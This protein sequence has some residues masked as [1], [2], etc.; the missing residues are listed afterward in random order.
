MQNW[1]LG[2]WCWPPFIWAAI[3]PVGAVTF[4]VRKLLPNLVT[5]PV[6]VL[7]KLPAGLTG[8]IFAAI[9][10]AAMSS[11]DSALN[12]LSAVTLASMWVGAREGGAPIEP[13][14]LATAGVIH[15]HMGEHDV[16]DV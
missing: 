13:S 4:H 5:V 16:A 14:A 12:S 3:V 11:L 2:R 9:L 6:F 15:V 7:Q 10:S 1:R 8:L